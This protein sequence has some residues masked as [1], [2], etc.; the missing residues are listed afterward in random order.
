MVVLTFLGWDQID[1]N[2]SPNYIFIIQSN[3]FYQILNFDL[4]NETYLKNSQIFR[5]F[6]AIKSMFGRFKIDGKID[7]KCSSYHHPH[8]VWIEQLKT[9]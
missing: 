5:C 7:E 6:M 4:S 1:M 8:K 3:K 9:S 2:R